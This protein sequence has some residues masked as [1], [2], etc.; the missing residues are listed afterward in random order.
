VG[1]GKGGG[2]KGRWRAA[3][4]SLRGK[5]ARRSAALPASPAS[6]SAP[7]PLPLPNRYRKQLQ[8]EEES[9]LRLK[10]ENGLLRKRF[11]EQQ[12]AIKEGKAAI[13][14]GSGEG[15]GGRGME[16]GS[17]AAAVTVDHNLNCPPGAAP[18]HPSFPPFHPPTG[19]PRA[20]SCSW[21]G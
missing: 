21:A 7:S 5:P 18:R 2:G 10:G 16:V 14:W 1:G 12:K 6:P 17:P 11:D 9:N 19:P 20:R 3:R 15:R 8:G 13:K 4:D